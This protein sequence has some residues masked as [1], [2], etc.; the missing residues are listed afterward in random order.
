MKGNPNDV[1]AHISLG[2]AYVE[3]GERQKAIAEIE[4]AMELSP[5]FRSQGEYFVRELRAGRNP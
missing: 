4:K 2:A 5:D 3:L 1:Q